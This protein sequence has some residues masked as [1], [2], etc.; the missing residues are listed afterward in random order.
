[1]KTRKLICI[2]L[3][4]VLIFGLSNSSLIFASENPS[5]NDEMTGELLP[6][7]D[8]AFYAPTIRQMIEVNLELGNQD[9]EFYHALANAWL[10]SS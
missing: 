5:E 7:A 2:L 6:T 10:H 9:E 8:N 3:S 4:V 1:M